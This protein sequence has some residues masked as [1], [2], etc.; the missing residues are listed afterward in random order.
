MRG[1]ASLLRSGAAIAL[2]VGVSSC[3]SGSSSSV[4][5]SVP[6]VPSSRPGGLT[7]LALGGL[8]H[9]S[10]Q[11]NVPGGLAVDGDVR[12]LWNA[13]AGPVQWIEVDLG[14]GRNVDE[15]RLS[16]AQS[17]KGPTTHVVLARGPAT[18]ERF[19]VLHTF[20]GKTRD[21]QTLSFKPGSAGHGIRVV[22][23]LTKAGPSFVAWREIEVHGEGS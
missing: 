3:T 20:R 14:A 22:R 8:V 23:I 4:R 6:A 21:G 17:L 10:T 7:N 2:M 13:G 9:A 16:V 1:R 12:T 15:I 11:S 18:S 19:I 5:P